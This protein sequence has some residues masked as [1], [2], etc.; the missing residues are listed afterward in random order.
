MLAGDVLMTT[1]M[2]GTLTHRSVFTWD[3][4]TGKDVYH[5]LILKNNLDVPLTTGP[6]MVLQNGKP[7]SQDE[8]KY[9]SAKAEG[10][11]KLTQTTDIR[12][13]VIEK[14]IERRPEQRIY[15]VMYIPVV[16]QGQL[17]VE[18]HRRETAD[19]EISWTVDGQV[20]EVT[21][22]AD[23][24][25]Q[26]KADQGLN[27]KSSLKCTVKIEPGEQHT[28]TFTYLHYVRARA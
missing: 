16:S 23:V 18:N 12:T 21:D 22:D 15:D 19:V 11:L 20:M 28:V 14:E 8:M 17:V 5:Y 9:I 4:D 3:V 27:P 13:N 1:I 24:Q 6:V 10:R 2:T 26:A 25:S 7:L